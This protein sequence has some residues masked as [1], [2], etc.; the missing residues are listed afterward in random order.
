MTGIYIHIPFCHNICTYCAFCKRY[1]DEDIASKYLDFLKIESLERINFSKVYQ[2]IYIGGGTP[3]SLSRENL[4]KLFNILDKIKLTNDYEFTFECNPE[5]IN[6]ELLT[7]LKTKRVNRLSIG[8]QSFNKEN[9]LL[10]GRS[11]FDIDKLELA[12][13]YFDNISLDLIYGIDFDS[14]MDDLDIFLSLDF[15]HI[16]LYSLMIEDNTLLKI[17]GFK[18]I[19]EELDEKMYNY[20]RKTLS[21]NGYNHYEIS[22]YAKNGY[23]SKH[24][25]IYWNNENY[26]GLGLGASSFIDNKHIKNTASFRKYPYDKEEIIENKES[27]IEYEI[28]LG[29]RK[30]K[31]INLDKFKEK[32]QIDINKIYDVDLLIKENLLDSKD[33]YLFIKEDKL[34]LENY[35]IGRLIT[36][37]KR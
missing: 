35:I 28:M 1:Y 37:E 11:N 9:L 32:Y 18:N 30:I 23:E 15:P 19:P 21:S 31:G 8:V 5:D 4:I 29:L 16:S 22:N 12:R 36:H 25:L 6:D 13:T 20:I 24:N 10:L 26:L 2:T 33:N 3:S 17:S 7:F 27:L 34:Y 14:L